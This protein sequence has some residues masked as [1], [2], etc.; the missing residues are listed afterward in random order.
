MEINKLVQ[1]IHANAVSHG[2]WDHERCFPEILA[3]IHSE[4]SEA[5]EEYRNG[6]EPTE[7][8]YSRRD[9]EKKP[10]GIPT[11]LAD[12]IIRILDYCGYAEIDIES[13]IMEK[14]AYNRSR[15]Y[16]HGGK[17]C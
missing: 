7:T 14:I 8:Y 9:R 5:L 11:E 2:W 17:V 6:H 4:V 3:L 10:E 13:A 15:P 16:R 1:Q 12:V